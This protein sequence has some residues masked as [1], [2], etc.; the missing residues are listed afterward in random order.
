MTDE[1]LAPAIDEVLILEDA[2][3]TLPVWQ[4]TGDPQ[5]DAALAELASLDEHD[6]DE[7]IAIFESVHRRLH[8]RLSDLSS[9]A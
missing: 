4:P 3:E 1:P 8:E 7:H 9:G 2:Q 6:R 5:V